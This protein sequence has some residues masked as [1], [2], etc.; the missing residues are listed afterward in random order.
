MSSIPA[1][2]IKVIHGIKF[3]IAGKCRRCGECEKKPTPC[4][5]LSFENGLA[6]CDTYGKGDYLEKRCD[7]FPDSPS[8]RVVREGICGIKFIPVGKESKKKYQE[9]MLKWLSHT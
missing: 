4:E 2:N 9:A 1:D 5:H 8:C 6:T 3:R 7:V